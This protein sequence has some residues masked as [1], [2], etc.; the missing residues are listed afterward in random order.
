MREQIKELLK[1]EEISF[2]MNDMDDL[3]MLFYTIEEHTDLCIPFT[4][5][6]RVASDGQD[7]WAQAEYY[8]SK[9]NKTII[10]SY[11]VNYMFDDE[12]ELIS[13]IE[14]TTKDINIFEERLLKLSK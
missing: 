11:D 1:Q 5:Q 9:L 8:S 14:N 10:W 3:N 6:V 4:V 13:F 12:D 2:P 7:A